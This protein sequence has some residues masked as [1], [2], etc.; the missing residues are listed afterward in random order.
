MIHH[1]FLDICVPGISRDPQT[2]P[3]I[4]PC[5]VDSDSVSLRYSPVIYIFLHNLH[6]ILGDSNA[7]TSLMISALDLNYPMQ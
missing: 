7:Q 3:W 5:H 6:R 4:T 1:L 2:L